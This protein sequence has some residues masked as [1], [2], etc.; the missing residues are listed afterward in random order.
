KMNSVMNR[1]AYL[2]ITVFLLLLLGCSSPDNDAPAVDRPTNTVSPL[3]DPIITPTPTAEPIIEQADL[4]FH[5]GILLTME[6]GFP[7]AQAIA[8]QGDRILAVGSD[9]DVLVLIG[10][11]TEVI[12]LNGQTLLPGLA[13]GHA[14]MLWVPPNMTLDEVQDIVFS[15]GFTSLNEMSA[16][17]GYIESLLQAEADGRLRLRVNVFPNYNSSRLND[18]R[19]SDIL[20]FWFPEHAPILDS[21]RMLRIPGIKFFVD[22]DG[23]PA[24]GCP[25]RRDPYSELSI[26]SDW[27]PR[28]CGSIYGDLYWDQTDLNQAVAAVQ[29]AGFRAAF[30][31]MGDRGIETALNAIE[32][33]LNGESNLFYRHQIQHSSILEPDLLERYVSEDILSSVRGYFNTCSQDS[34]HTEW[35]SNRYALPGAGV[36]AYLETDTRWIGDIHDITWSSTLNSMVQLFGLVTKQQIQAD[37]SVCMPD[38]WIA[39]HVITVDQ[40][41]YMMT[42][43][44][45]YAVSQEDVLGSLTPGKYADLVILSEDPHSVAPGNLKNLEVRMTMVGGKVEYCKGGHEALCPNLQPLIQSQEEPEAGPTEIPPEAVT[46]KIF[47]KEP[48]T[49]S[50]GT[51]I[52]ISIG[53]AANTEEQLID[54]LNA[55]S[56]TATLD[57][58]SLAGLNDNWSEISTF[59]SNYGDGLNYLSSWEYSLGVLSPGTHQIEITGTLAWTITDGFSSSEDGSLEQY[60]GEVMNYTLIIYVEE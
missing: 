38:P 13:D 60:S 51:P 24:R 25:A 50:A 46:I 41:L 16:D 22:G 20:E 53:W 2:L 56:F 4:I 37:G 26:S 27:F 44:P 11:D 31:A 6:D 35:A 21:D 43:E 45:A 5:N 9:E 36:H 57:S 48:T 3:A 23:T 14:H 39:K 42:Y 19:E 30:H 7:T 17:N 49:V 32:F 34:Y 33:A 10:P 47:K 8:I 18:E 58:Q 52:V 29:A 59:E 28:A 54:F 12:D 1:I 40:A 15:Y 55:I